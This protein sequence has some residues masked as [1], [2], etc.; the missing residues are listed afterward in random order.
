M[1]FIDIIASFFRGL[2]DWF[3]WLSNH[4][5]WVPILGDNLSD[6]FGQFGSFFDVIASYT[7]QLSWHFSRLWDEVFERISPLLRR[8]EGWVDDLLRQVLNL[9]IELYNWVWRWI[10]DLWLDIQKL[11]VDASS[12]VENLR[13]DVTGR[14]SWMEARLNFDLD[15]SVISNKVLG[16]LE[17]R[18]E[19]LAERLRRIAERV[20]I[21]LW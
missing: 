19:S 21:A 5:R 4:I 1:W 18:A 6:A 11:R 17:D 3:W 12:W 7:D 14:L 2:R 8:V 20:L 9:R 16:W 13:A 15:T 10:S